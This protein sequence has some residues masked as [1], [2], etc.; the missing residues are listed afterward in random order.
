[1]TVAGNTVHPSGSGEAPRE[2]GSGDSTLV[3]A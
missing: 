3:Y 1:M 2:S